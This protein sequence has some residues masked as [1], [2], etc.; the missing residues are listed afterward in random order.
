M[1]PTWA[2][3]LMAASVRRG[4]GSWQRMGERGGRACTSTDSGWQ[5]GDLS[6][7]HCHAAG[8]R[9]NTRWRRHPPAL[10]PGAGVYAGSPPAPSAVPRAPQHPIL[11][12]GAIGDNRLPRL[13]RTLILSPCSFISLPPHRQNAWRHNTSDYST[14]AGNPHPLAIET[15]GKSETL[16]RPSP[17]FGSRN[18]S[19]AARPSFFSLAP[20]PHKVTRTQ[21]RKQLSHTHQ[22]PWTAGRRAAQYMSST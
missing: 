7:V 9:P 8:T 3:I 4:G 17:W 20:I 15:L 1:K 21:R 14:S 16:H 18:P 5:D 13:C 22:T 6:F 19:A 10:R 11:P 2:S 12:G